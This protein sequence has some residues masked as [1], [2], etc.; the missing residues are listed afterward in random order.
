MNWLAALHFGLIDR[1]C[2]LL[3]GSSAAVE[4][5]LEPDS[6]Q[7]LLLDQLISLDVKCLFTARSS[8]Q[9]GL[10]SKGGVIES[11]VRDLERQRHHQQSD[12]QRQ[13]T[14]IGADVRHDLGSD[15]FDFLLDGRK[16]K[17]RQWG[18]A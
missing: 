1:D 15:R 17:Q 7:L 5:S 14:G 13:V 10:E 6:S 11:Q 16:P 8:Q 9:F 3:H 4:D 2:A 12:P 18:G